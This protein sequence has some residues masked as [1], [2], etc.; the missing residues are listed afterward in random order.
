MGA[1]SVTVTDANGCQAVCS[2][3]C[4]CNA[5]GNQGCTPG[6]WKQPQHFSDWTDP[7][8]PTDLF[9]EHFENAF[10][11]KTLL[12]VL[13][14]PASSPPGP[15]ALNSL[16]RHTV[17]ALLNAA[18]RNVNFGFTPQ[19]VID[20]FNAVFPGT[21]AE[22]LA[23]KNIFAAANEAGCPLNGHSDLNADGLVGPDDLAV[24]LG[25]W[26]GQG[27]GDLNQ[28]GV[29][30]PADLAQLLAYWGQ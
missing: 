12:T 28:D 29:V 15:N 11:G 20:M 22:Y 16:G 9:S 26:G 8:D 21:D 5:V 2:A 30:N 7:Y 27:A 1:F 4:G 17:A 18:N 23:L 14:Q 6:Y 10:P 19:Q 25:N 13:S 3:L 24:L